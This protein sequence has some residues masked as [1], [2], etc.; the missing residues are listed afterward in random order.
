[1]KIFVAVW[2]PRHGDT[3]FAF[4][5]IEGAWEQKR[6]I[7]DEYWRQERIEEYCHKAGIAIP[8]DR[9]ARADL[10]FDIV[11]DA[12]EFFTIEEA[13]LDSHG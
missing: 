13:E 3:V 2:E 6:R 7:A 11:G 10:Y 9:Q 1:M 5:D 4:S 12:G 8:T